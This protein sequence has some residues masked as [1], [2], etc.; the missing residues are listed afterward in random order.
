THISTSYLL[1]TADVPPAY[2]TARTSGWRTGPAAVLARLADP[3]Q[4]DAV[5]P[6]E[7]LF[8]IVAQLE[9]GDG[10]YR[11]RVNAGGFV[12]RGDFPDA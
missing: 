9:T 7:Y 4:A 12:I 3:A 11:E 2:I 5:D 8:R 1:R 10:R 6:R